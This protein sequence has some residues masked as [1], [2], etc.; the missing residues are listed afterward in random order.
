MTSLPAPPPG[1][2]LLQALAGAEQGGAELHFF[3]LAAAFQRAGVTQHVV[4]RGHDKAVARLRAAEVH[5]TLARFGGPLDFSTGRI[6]RT[7]AGALRPNLVLA[8][9]ARAAK[10]VPRG[11]YQIVGRLGGYYDLKYFRNCD[12]LVCI[13]PDLVDYVVKAGWPRDRVT[14]IPNFVDDSTS[15]PLTRA[16]FTTP[17]DAPLVAAV[18]RLH[19]N[20][21][22]DTLLRAIEKLPGL[23][24]WIAG[25]GEERGALEALAKELGISDRVR[26][27][28]WQDDPLAAIKAADVYVVPSRHEP[29]GSVVLEGWMA[30]KPMVAAASQGPS[31][32]ITEGEDGLLVPIDAPQAMADA[33]ARV[34]QDAALAK[35]LSTS[36][37]RRFEEGFTQDVAVANYFTLFEKLLREGRRT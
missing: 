27:I 28:G 29:L 6:L 9:M 34:L 2:R 10:A 19:R 32:L 16:A 25:E 18:G 24:L 13:T 20:K 8:Y 36:G 22:F 5:F 12:H 17:S 30:G 1:L 11:P 35:R 33:I 4:T 15:A 7:V 3:R 37:R 26:L 31:W 21:A 14:C 23:W